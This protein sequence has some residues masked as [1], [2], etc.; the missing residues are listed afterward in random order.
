MRVILLSFFENKIFS[1]AKILDAKYILPEGFDWDEI[2]RSGKVIFQK[3][4]VNSVL[5]MLVNIPTKS[6]FSSFK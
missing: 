2:N 1:P 3:S 5:M 6:A 4:S